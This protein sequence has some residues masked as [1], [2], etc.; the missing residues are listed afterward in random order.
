MVNYWLCVTNEENWNVIKERN[1]WGVP[2]K[3]GRRLIEDVRPGDLLVFYVIPKRIGGI[4]RAVSEP[5]ESRERV[6]SCLEFGRDEIF[7]YRVK[8]EPSIIPKE[9]LPFEGVIERLSFTSKVR[10]WS[11]LLRRAMFRISPEDFA[12]IKDFI[13]SGHKT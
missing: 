8:I 1:I 12:V 13:S 3:R 2:E 5:F 4:F 9:P 10:R 11:L 6:F 7:P